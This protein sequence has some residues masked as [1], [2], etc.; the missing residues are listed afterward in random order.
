MRRKLLATDSKSRY[1]KL[2]RCYK[3][4]NNVYFPWSVRILDI[5]MLFTKG[6]QVYDKMISSHLL[7]ST[8][9]PKAQT[10]R[11]YTASFVTPDS[12]TEYLHRVEGG[13]V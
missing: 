13:M 9:N 7:K 1:I 6:P 12:P 2:I 11:I 3:Y 8:Y 4:W 5:D 10:L